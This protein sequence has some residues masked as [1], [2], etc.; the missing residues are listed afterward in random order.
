MVWGS[1]G[2]IA[3]GDLVKIDV[4]K[5]SKKYHNILV[6]YS[7]PSGNRIIG[8]RSILQQDNDPKHTSSLCRKYVQ[9]K[10][11]QQ[12]LQIVFNPNNV[13]KSCKI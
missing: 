5:Y 2:G 10:Q 3:V 4:I 8:L 7:I 6:Q 1:F 13:D 12:V 11:R 9:S